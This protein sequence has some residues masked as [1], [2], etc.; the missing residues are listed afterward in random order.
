M[1]E[2]TFRRGDQAVVVI[3]ETPGAVEITGAALSRLLTEVSE[4]A[5]ETRVVL[6]LRT[7][8]VFELLELT[9]WERAS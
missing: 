9:G 6:T 3:E 4:T 5:D 7:G 8:E 1:R 2:A